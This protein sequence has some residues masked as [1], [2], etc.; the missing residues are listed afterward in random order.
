MSEKNKLPLNFAQLKFIKNNR[1]SLPRDAMLAR[2]MLSCVCLSV[3]L[4]VR[5]KPALYKN[6]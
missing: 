5:H 4:F 2:Y 6:G 3:R 1:L